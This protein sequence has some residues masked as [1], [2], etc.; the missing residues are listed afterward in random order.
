MAFVAT[1][2]PT[3]H[4]IHLFCCLFCSRSRVAS[5][6][7][8]HRWIMMPNSGNGTLLTSIGSGHKLS[9]WQQF[10]SIYKHQA[11]HTQTHALQASSPIRSIWLL[12]IW[13]VLVLYLFI[14]ARKSAHAYMLKEESGRKRF[15]KHVDSM[16]NC[17]KAIIFSF[18]TNC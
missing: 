14:S 6:R 17:S 9:L 2:T 4:H 11:P 1:T 10:D 3:Q 12:A 13:F 16:A 5:A 7:V 8:V 15:N 18:Q